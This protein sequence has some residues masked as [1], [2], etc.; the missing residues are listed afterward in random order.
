MDFKLWAAY[1]TSSRGIGPMFQEQLNE[2]NGTR[3]M[4]SRNSKQGGSVQKSIGRT[5]SETAGT[6]ELVESSSHRRFGSA[7]LETS[8]V[9]IPRLGAKADTAKDNG[10]RSEIALVE[11]FASAPDSR[12]AFTRGRESSPSCTAKNSGWILLKLSAAFESVP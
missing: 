9:M 12:S 2:I 4:K 7:P 11:L 5:I 3:W 8:S 10:V 1:I 6:L